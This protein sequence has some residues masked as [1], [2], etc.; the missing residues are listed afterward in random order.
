MLS[1]TLLDSERTMRLEDIPEPRATQLRILEDAYPE[2]NR[3][4]LPIRYVSDTRD[5]SIVEPIRYS[6]YQALDRSVLKPLLDAL[7]QG[8]I[9]LASAL[10]PEGKR[11]C[12]YRVINEPFEH[13]CYGSYAADAWSVEIGRGIYP[14]F[15]QQFQ[16][17]EVQGT[18][19]NE[20]RD[21]PGLQFWYD[22]ITCFDSLSP[23]S[24]GSYRTVFSQSYG[25][26]VAKDLLTRQLSPESLAKGNHTFLIHPFQ[27]KEIP[28]IYQGEQHKTY[29]IFDSTLPEL[30]PRGVN[31]MTL[32]H[33]MSD[34]PTVRPRLSA[35]LSQAQARVET[36]GRGD[37]FSGYKPPAR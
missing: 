19:T 12:G 20:V 36:Q 2:L 23:D 21:Y 28:F 15:A 6:P 1:A 18:F 35:T 31:P 25:H 34:P 32:R 24:V 7:E 10:T 16:F 5:L 17:N 26:A 33:G 29:G 8:D 3:E 30:L 4:Q 13:M 14:I 37:S 27:A 22:G 9:E 11:L